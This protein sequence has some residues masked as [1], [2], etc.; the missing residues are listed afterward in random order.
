[1]TK[2]KVTDLSKSEVIPV[3]YDRMSEQAI[4]F[5]FDLLGVYIHK[6]LEMSKEKDYGLLNDSQMI[7]LD[8][9]RIYMKRYNKCLQFKI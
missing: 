4:R 5:L 7:L 8:L 6:E 9:Q 2:I 1:M 3:Y